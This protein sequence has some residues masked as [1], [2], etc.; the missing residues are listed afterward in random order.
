MSREGT[1]PTSWPSITLR[2]A[3]DYCPIHFV[4]QQLMLA[5]IVYFCGGPQEHFWSLGM[6]MG[7]ALSQSFPWRKKPMQI[8][9]I[10]VK[11]SQAGWSAKIQNAPRCI[12]GPPNSNPNPFKVTSPSQPSWS[13]RS[14]LLVLPWT[15]RCGDLPHICSDSAC[16]RKKSLVDK[17]RCT[18]LYM[19]TRVLLC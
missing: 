1:G 10:G 17:H 11:T 2:L 4:L 14:A 15:M 18:H 7:Q 8:D 19:H 12:W 16:G 3:L 6:A 9:W 5:C 13:P